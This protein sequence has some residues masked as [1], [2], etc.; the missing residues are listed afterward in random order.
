LRR[1][2]GVV[3]ETPLYKM[4]DAVGFVKSWRWYYTTRL[5]GIALIMYGL[6]IDQTP[7]RGTILL[8]GFGLLGL[9]RVARSDAGDGP[10][11]RSKKE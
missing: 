6:L 3:S 8:G 1:R 9:D 11:P 7:E 4:K 10:P 2:L 5:M